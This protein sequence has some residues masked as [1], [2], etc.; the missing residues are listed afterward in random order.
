MYDFS[1]RQLIS[2]HLA[3]FG[4]LDPGIE[5]GA[6]IEITQDGVAAAAGIT[7]AHACTVLLRMEKSGEVTIGLSRIKGS[8][9]RVRR[10]VYF[11]TT[12]G[13]E[14]VD[15]LLSDLEAS[16]VPA[17]ELS[18]PPTVNRMSTDMMR[19]LSQKDRDTMGMLC[20]LRHNVARGDLESDPPGLLYDGKG[21]LVLKDE[22][23]R[24]FL[25]TGSEEERRRWHSLAADM[26]LDDDALVSERLHHLRM[27]GRRKEA[28]R[29]AVGNV[30]RLTGDGDAM[31]D[32]IDLCREI[33]DEGLRTMAA[34]LALRSGDMRRAREALES[35][36]GQFGPVM[37][38]VLLA[39]GDSKGA[40][41]MALRSYSGDAMSALAL[42]K[43][44]NA[45]G[46][47]EEALV[48]LTTSRRRMMESGSLF[49]MDEE[50]E[51][52]AEAD[53]ALGRKE[54]A[55]ALRKAAEAARR[56]RLKGRCCP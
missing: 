31:D 6:P 45:A 18:T 35:G 41:D 15:R 8:N 37:S 28:A 22:V 34:T 38:E 32:L 12:L 24:R 47:H 42:G 2:L 50:M 49:R 1:V 5:F 46:R 14:R 27:A 16:G 7:R 23:R 53:E 25:E 33:D 43:A 3:K 54:R 44:M 56:T 40:L 21:A 10:K 39:E 36:G 9:C 55:S 26:C 19:G 13:K 11:L 30:R 17:S 29:L 48:Y 20:V 51:A 4:Y 52:E